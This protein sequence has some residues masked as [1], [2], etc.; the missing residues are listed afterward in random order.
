MSRAI[1]SVLGARLGCRADGELMLEAIQRLFR[2]L[3]LQAVNLDLARGAACSPTIAIDNVS[4]HPDHFRRGRG[5]AKRRRTSRR[6]LQKRKD[7]AH[8][9]RSN[10]LIS[11]VRHRGSLRIITSP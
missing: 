9:S 3:Q 5:S 1:F 11:H 10:A 8:P 4:S 6:P 2:R 7:F